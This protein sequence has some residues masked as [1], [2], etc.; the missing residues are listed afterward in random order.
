M[1][2]F[3]FKNTSLSLV[4]SKYGCYLGTAIIEM[5]AEEY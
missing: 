4:Q 1:T 3:V 5:Q 2:E